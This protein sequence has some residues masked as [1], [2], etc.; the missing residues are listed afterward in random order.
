MIRV[1]VVDDSA[2]IR[3]VLA[4][5]LKT[6]SELEVV[7]EAKDGVEAV[8]MS[9]SLTPDVIA[10]DYEMPRMNGIDALKEIM[11][12][13]PTPVVMVS[14]YT[15]EG[16]R[17]TLQAL[18]EGA[19]DFISKDI[20]KGT[21][22]IF[23]KKEEIISKIKSAARARF[24]KRL[25]PSPTPSIT[26]PSRVVSSTTSAQAQ[27]Y[28]QGVNKVVVIGAS[29]GGP[30][31]VSDLLV[32]LRKDLPSAFLIVIHMPAVFTATFAERL[33]EKTG[34]KVEEA[35]DG[36]ILRNGVFFVA[37]GGVHTSVSA[38]G[39]LRVS[40][41]PSNTIWRPSIDIA[42]TTCSKIFGPKCIGVILTGMGNDGTEGMKAIKQAGGKTIAQDEET[43]VV[44]GM[45]KS[46]V[47]ANAV[48]VVSDLH[49]IPNVIQRFI[50]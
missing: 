35:K 24:V 43:S 36:D 31:A 18:E 19:V 20:E 38:G 33:A 46:V 30:Q 7:G 34:L 40:P 47:E 44:Y 5:L 6:D 1:L 4:D 27:L 11:K 8:Q 22:E 42:M 37:P 15:K 39:V 2:F 17:V 32:M 49:S 23:R 10:L 29:T 28:T 16:A 3:K 9:L 41:Q 25:T 21:F 13:R 12:K 14:S 26:Q 45:P 50:C 48:D